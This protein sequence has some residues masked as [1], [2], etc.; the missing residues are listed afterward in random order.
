M[1]GRGE[2]SPEHL[3]QLLEETNFTEKEINGFYKFGPG[4]T[5]DRDD[6]VNLCSAN[7]LVAPGMT[8]RMWNLFDE[9]DDGC[10]SDFELV[11]AL[12]PLMRGTLDDVAKMFFDLYDVNGDDELT[13]PEIVSVYSDL[14][15]LSSG[16]PDRT[17]LSA[18]QRQKITTFVT[19]AKD[20]NST[21]K[22]DQE[23]FVKVVR[24]MVEDADVEPPFCSPRTVFFIFVTAWSEVGTSF[25]LPAMGALSM[26]IQQRFEC[27]ASEIGSLTALYYG[28]A[29]VGP[30]IGGMFMDKYGPGLVVIG[31]NVLVTL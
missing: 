3:A 27:G 18:E 5:L 1:S 23:T 4:D 26:R 6:F 17:G 22:L 31:A 20:E 13:I 15:R 7:G 28:A 10:C 11:K 8:L 2:P 30:M 16:E 24:Q 12:N 29:I 9:D 19:L 25:A 21:G 14:I